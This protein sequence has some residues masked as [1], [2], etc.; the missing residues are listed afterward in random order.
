MFHRHDIILYFTV[1]G[2]YCGLARH[3]RLTAV[4]RVIDELPS[5]AQ[6]ARWYDN[7][8]F[9]LPR[10]IM[11]PGNPPLPLEMTEGGYRENGQIFL[12]R[13]SGDAARVLAHWNQLYQERS[14]E[15]GDVRVCFPLRVNVFEG[16]PLSDSL[17]AQIFG[18]AGFPNTQFRPAK[19]SKSLVES[20]LRRTGNDDVIE[21]LETA[22]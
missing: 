15:L 14:E 18:D 11:V 9:V 2:R 10:N 7:S 19:V 13:D 1:K 5:H 17:V 3:R 6:A 20:V 4:L 12:P 16:F 8:G 21:K 22:V